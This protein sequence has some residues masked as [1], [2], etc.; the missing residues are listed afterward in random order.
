MNLLVGTTVF[1]ASADL[2]VIV[3]IIVVD[4]VLIFVV[5][6]GCVAAPVN[7]TSCTTAGLLLFSTIPL[8]LS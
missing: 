5:V 7:V 8:T 6:L 2:V 3:G 1:D 4:I